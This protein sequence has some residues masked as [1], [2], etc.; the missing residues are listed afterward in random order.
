MARN[1][2]QDMIVKVTHPD[3]ELRR[4]RLLI[5]DDGTAAVFTKKAAPTHVLRYSDINVMRGTMTLEDGR[6]VRFRR[7]GS[8]CTYALAKCQVKSLASYWPEEQA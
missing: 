2:T 5:A 6:E 7:V 1:I 8:S 3:F 4:A